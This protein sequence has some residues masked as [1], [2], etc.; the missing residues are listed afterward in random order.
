LSDNEDIKDKVI[1]IVKNQKMNIKEKKHELRKILFQIL[2]SKLA[3]EYKLS[4]KGGGEKVAFITKEL[5]SLKEYVI[6]NVRDYCMINKTKDKC[7]SNI[8]CM[9]KDDSCKLQ[10]YQNV[11]VEFV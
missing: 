8:H 6:S 3:A 1:Q 11:A 9:W 5:P 10:I 2:D 4:Q 7:S